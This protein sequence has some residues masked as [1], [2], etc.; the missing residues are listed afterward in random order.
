MLTTILKLFGRSPFAPLSSHMERVSQ[1]VYKLKE[2]F[3][4]IEEGNTEAH[5]HIVDE[6]SELEHHADITK[7]DIRNHLPKSLFMPIDRAQFLEILSLQDTIADTVQDIAILTTLKPLKFSPHFRDNFYDFLE[8]NF[9]TFDCALRII[10]ELHELLES[11]FGGV[12]A[13]KVLHMVNQVA[14]KE[15]EVDMIQRTL[16]QNFFECD[17]EMSYPSFYL[18]DK[19]FENVGKISNLSEKLGYRIRMTLELK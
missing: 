14:Y 18:W 9:D 5:R 4:A 6:I 2:L 8:K 1:C 7:N 10:E 16:L 11:S 13:E 3:P 19:I 17:E 12:E 15:H